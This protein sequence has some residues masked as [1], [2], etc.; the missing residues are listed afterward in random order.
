MRSFEKIRPQRA[1]SNDG[2]AVYTRD[3]W[4]IRYERPDRYCDLLCRPY[5]D[6]NNKFDG[7]EIA[8]SGALFEPLCWHFQDG[9]K[10]VVT[11]VEK[12]EICDDVTAAYVVLGSHVHFVE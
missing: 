8:M 7:L 11:K 5:L 6:E 2:V 1:Q 3:R 4:A 10:M 9:T 12:Q